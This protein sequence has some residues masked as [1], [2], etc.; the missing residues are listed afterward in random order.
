MEFKHLTNLCEFIANRQQFVEQ[1]TDEGD[2]MEEIK[3]LFAEHIFNLI[4]EVGVAESVAND[5]ADT[6]ADGYFTE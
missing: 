4:I 3:R 1:M 5:I 2:S 6:L